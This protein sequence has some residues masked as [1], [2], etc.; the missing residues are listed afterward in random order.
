MKTISQLWCNSIIVF[1]GLSTG[2]SDPFVDIQFGRHKKKT[3]YIT[4][5]LNPKWENEQ[6]QFTIVN[7]DMPN[8]L[9]LR[10][11]DWNFLMPSYDLGYVQFCS[12]SQ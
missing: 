4:K 12:K 9:T 10:M 2:S 1:F 6:H 3:K 11:R 7:W 5:T 8:L